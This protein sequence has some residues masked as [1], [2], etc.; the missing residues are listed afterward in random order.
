VNYDCDSKA[1]GGA[2]EHRLG[3]VAFKTWHNV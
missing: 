2:Q 3:P 1:S